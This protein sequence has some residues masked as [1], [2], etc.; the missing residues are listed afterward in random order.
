M[1]LKILLA[2]GGTAGHINPALAIAGYVLKRRPD[3]E[4][5]FVGTREGMEADLV[6]KEGFKI[7]YADVRGFKRKFSAYNLGA[8]VRAVTSLFDAKK[9][10]KDFKPDVVI[11]TGGYVSGPILYMAAK[12]GYKTAIH[13]QNVFPGFTSRVLSRYVDRVMI[14][15]DDSRKYFK[16]SGKLTLVGNPIRQEMIYCKREESRKELILDHRPLVVSF[17]GSLGARE[18]NKT[19]ISML[20]YIIRDGAIQFI[21]ACGDRGYKWVPDMIKEKGI[22]LDKHADV[23]IE[24]YIYDMPRV[25]AAS[26][27]VIS[28]AGA[29]TL[30]EL[31]ACGKPSILIP[32][33]NVTHN[34][35]QINAQSFEKIGAAKVI[36]E[37]ELC[38]QKL[39]GTI[40]SLLK[41]PDTLKLM[42][43]NALKLAVFDSVEK[44]Y[45]E[46]IQLTDK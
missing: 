4:I 10:L 14:S 5:A 20:E 27:L 9:I 45:S 31:A 38:A 40:L 7:Y 6:P 16:D 13:E 15:F 23:R 26:D 25:M 32:S 29:I 37:K 30:S 19:I 2:G 34:H 36:L 28:R 12:E 3:S 11:G 18:I 22:E 24:R 44:I 39:Y 1:S 8:A 35:Q 33:P 21:H 42:S 17:A 46:I 43:Q 41:A